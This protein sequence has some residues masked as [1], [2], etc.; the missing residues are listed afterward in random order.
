LVAAKKQKNLLGQAMKSEK[1]SFKT[2][3]SPYDRQRPISWSE[4]FGRRAPLDVEIGFGMGEVL[5]RMA[6][7]SPERDFVGIEQHWERMC[8]TM[9]AITRKQTETTGAFENIRILR[10]DARAAFERLFPAQSIDTIYCLFPCPWPKKGHIKHRL[11]AHDF[12]RLSNNR[13][14]S[15]GGVKIV[16]DFYPY[17]EWILEESQGT[18]FQVGT[19]KIRPQYDTKFERKWHE[20]GQEEFFEIDLLKKKHLLVPVKKDT[21]LKSYAL[22]DFDAGRMQ[23]K[24]VTGETAVVFKETVFDKDKQRMMVHSLVAEQHLTQHFWI[25]I[26]RTQKAWKVIPSDGQNFFPTPGIARALA[27]VYEA[28]K[29][30]IP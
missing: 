27:M 22:K 4:L 5:I 28:A 18:G 30:T 19:R 12:L 21:V 13:L 7:R 17:C 25:T 6:Q 11:F 26:A 23:L 1:C 20:E 16:T 2:L 8:K 29:E 24:D 10:M 9:R 14:K 15:S 3:I